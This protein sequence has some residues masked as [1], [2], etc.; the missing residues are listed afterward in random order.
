MGSIF[1]KPADLADR[2][3][4]KSLHG[5]L[6]LWSWG[7]FLPGGVAMRAAADGEPAAVVVHWDEAGAESVVPLADFKRL[8]VGAAEESK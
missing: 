3:F 5:A 1:S 4:K 2:N 7:V 8:A 6:M